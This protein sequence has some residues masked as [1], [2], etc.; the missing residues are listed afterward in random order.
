VKIK[1]IHIVGL[2]GAY[3]ALRFFLKQKTTKYGPIIQST[4][5]ALIYRLKINSGLD[6]NQ[7]KQ[8]TNDLSVEQIKD[9]IY[10][11]NL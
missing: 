9:Y 10:Q 1:L 11:H 3:F 8:I 7:V 6:E 5:E 2:V 4:R